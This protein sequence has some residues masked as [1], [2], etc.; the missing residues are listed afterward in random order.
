MKL[1]FKI[2]LAFNSIMLLLIVYLTKETIWLLCLGEYTLALY[3]AIPI[4]ISAICLALANCL[5]HD[6]IENGIENV[7]LA[8]D[9]YLPGYLGYFFVALSI[10]EGNMITLCF[11]FGMLFVFSFCSQSLYYNPIFLLFGYKFYYLTKEN[12]MK[13]LL[14]SKRKIMKAGDLKFDDLRRINDFTFIDKE[15]NHGSCDCKGK[16]QEE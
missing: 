11:I 10:P 1:L 15:K 16:G 4:V 12:G 14:I 9:S 2:M 6:S 8:N 3:V 7:E 13:I 5:S